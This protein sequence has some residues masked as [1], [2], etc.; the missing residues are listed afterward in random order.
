MIPNPLISKLVLLQNKAIL[1]TCS[2]VFFTLCSLYSIS[3]ITEFCFTG[4][5]NGNEFWVYINST[6]CLLHKFEQHVTKICHFL[7]RLKTFI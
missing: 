6:I 7:S 1:T 5:R 2:W 3:L 4:F